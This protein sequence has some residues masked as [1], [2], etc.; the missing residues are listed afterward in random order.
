MDVQDQPIPLLDL[1]QE[2]KFQAA[3]ALFL[4][5]AQL[6]RDLKQNDLQVVGGF[7]TLQL[8]LAA[9]LAEHPPMT[10]WGSL[11]LFGLSIILSFLS[12]KFLEK[13]D[14][15]RAQVVASLR[16][17][18]AALRFS[19]KEIYIKGA[20]LDVQTMFEP[21]LRLYEGVLFLTILGVGVV[22]FGGQF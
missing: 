2:Q 18:K 9:W 14:R 15:R 4:D 21:S 1:S 16:N 20:A 22:I 5:Q 7:I 12:W 10:F 6:I 19:Q 13:S 17:T 11:G 8:A 3:L